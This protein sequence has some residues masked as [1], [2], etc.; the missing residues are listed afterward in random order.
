MRKN[1]N[2]FFAILPVFIILLIQFFDK[3]AN[4]RFVQYIILALMIFYVI[5]VKLRKKQ[6]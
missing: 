4:Y 3:E 1:K 6:T 2:S 5:Y